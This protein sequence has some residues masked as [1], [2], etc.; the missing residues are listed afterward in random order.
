M[1]TAISIPDP[2][3]KA[4]D[5]IAKRKGLSRSELYTRAIAALVREED[6]GEVTAQ[7]NRV[8]EREDS[9]LDATLSTLPAKILDREDW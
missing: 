5:R 6:D 4:A 1:K 9:K 2:V 3:F 7:L 8:Y